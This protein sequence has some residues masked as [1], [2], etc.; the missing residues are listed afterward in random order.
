VYISVSKGITHKI[1]KDMSLNKERNV[2]LIVLDDDRYYEATFLQNKFPSYFEKC[3]T[4]IRQIIDLKDIPSDQ[5]MYASHSAKIGWVKTKD[6]SQPNRKSRLLICEKW[7]HDNIRGMQKVKYK[8]E[9]SKKDLETLVLKEIENSK[10]ELDMLVLK[11]TD[12]MKIKLTTMI[13]K[14][15]EDIEKEPDMLNLKENDNAH[16]KHKK[17]PELLILTDEEKFKDINGQIFEIEVRGTK[18]QDGLYFLAKDIAV[19]FEM[20]YNNFV[21][22]LTNKNRGYI[23]HVHYE[24]FLC[25]I[26]HGNKINTYKRVYLTL[27]GFHRVVSVSR[28]H[29]TAK[30]EMIIT[31]WVSKVLPKYT[32]DIIVDNADIENNVG[33]VYV[34]S[35]DLM[36]VVKIGYWTGSLADLRSRYVTYYGSTVGI[37]TKYT[38]FPRKFEHDL[39]EYFKKYNIS[40]ELFKKEHSNEYIKYM[41]NHELAICDD[42]GEKM[43]AMKKN[44]KTVEST[45]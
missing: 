34:V 38:M 1:A 13:L 10:K 29:H 31:N 4:S 17:A 11:E 6:Q 42:D 26:P 43:M 41:S 40:G 36:T 28:S 3:V 2:D 16:Q 39:H 19:L 30:N 8:K 25:D 5:Y 21:T 32:K 35:S 9:N 24:T 12:N 37:F 27:K 15:N 33:V 18:T 14:E 45:N 7:A 23:R 20:D 22:T 44:S